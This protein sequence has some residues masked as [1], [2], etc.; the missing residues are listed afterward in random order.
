M[1]RTQNSSTDDLK[2][3]LWFPM[4]FVKI[5]VTFQDYCFIHPIKFMLAIRFSKNIDEVYEPA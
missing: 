3:R 1:L 2:L 4:L 5:R